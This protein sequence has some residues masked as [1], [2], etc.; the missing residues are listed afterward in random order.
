M[1]PNG[2]RLQDLLDRTDLIDLLAGIT[3]YVD[4]RDF[5]GLAG[6]YTPDAMLELP[7]IVVNGI[8][9]ISEV[10]RA[11][12]ESY[13]RT[14]HFIS[15][16]LVTVDGD[17]AEVGADVM[18]VMVGSGESEAAPRVLGSRYTLTA[19]RTVPGWR[20][21]RHVITPIWDLPPA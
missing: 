3:R 2:Q 7:G 1:T 18:A 21:V 19:V 17:R 10:A 15:G 20:F 12:H 4:A 9:A 5:A 11:G 13:S 8:S 16:P 6:V 14:Q